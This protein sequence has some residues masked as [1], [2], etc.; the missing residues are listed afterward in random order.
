MRRLVATLGLATLIGV[1]PIPGR[2]QAIS[3][4]VGCSVGRVL[5]PANAWRHGEVRCLEQRLG[6]LGYLARRRVDGWWTSSTTAAITAAQRYLTAR[7][8]PAGRPGI[9]DRTFLTAIGLDA[10]L[11]ATAPDPARRCVTVG[12]LGDSLTFQGLGPLVRALDSSGV[13]RIVVSAHGFRAIMSHVPGDLDTGLTAAQWMRGRGIDCWIVAMGT[14][15]VVDI[16]RGVA[17]YTAGVAIGAMMRAIDPAGAAPVLWVNLFT[18]PAATG[19]HANIHMAAFD[20]ALRQAAGTWSNLRI[21]DWAATSP[22]QFK[23]DGVHPTA[24]GQQARAAWIAAQ[25]VAAVG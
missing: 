13:G 5:S 1:S 8:W 22:T 2:A 14:N 23:A 9:A 21:A 7:G 16:A 11:V 25:L 24:L 10:S 3:A 20:D 12:V 19:A 4:P 18:S 15:D 6:D 17:T